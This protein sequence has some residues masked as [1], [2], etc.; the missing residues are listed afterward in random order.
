[1]D[2]IVSAGTC[3]CYGIVMALRRLTLRD[4]LSVNIGGW[5]VTEPVS[6][7]AI[8]RA[9]AGPSHSFVVHNPRSVP[10]ISNRSR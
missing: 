2:L 10:K 6:F 4:N 7:H 3:R 1:M 9:G 8:M 5:L